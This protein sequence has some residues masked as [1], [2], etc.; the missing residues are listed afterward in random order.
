MPRTIAICVVVIVLMAAGRASAQDTSNIEVMLG[1]YG[2]I[3]LDGTTYRCTNADFASGA[4][5]ELT[6]PIGSTLT[7]TAA[8][9]PVTGPETTDPAPDP[10]VFPSSFVGW[11]RPECEGAGPSCTFTVEDDPE[12][13]VAHFSPVW[14]E[15]LVAGEGTVAANG[16]TSSCTTGRCIMGPFV[17]GTRVDVTATPDPVWGFGC[18]PFDSDLLA[19]H[20]VIE[21]S[22]IRNFVSVG[23]QDLEPDA[24]PPY[25]LSKP[26][27]VKR[28]GSGEGRV[29]GKGTDAGGVD[30]SIDCGSDCKL[31]GI[32]YQTRVRLRADEAAG[33]TF[34]RWSGPPCGGQTICTFTAGKYPTVRATFS[35]HASASAASLPSSSTLGSQVRSE[36]PFDASLVRVAARGRRA[37]RKIVVTLTTNRSARATLRLTRRGRRVTGRS[38]ALPA[39]THTIRVKVPRRAR[40]GWYRMSLAV[41]AADGTR[42]SFAKR[43]RLR[44]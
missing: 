40:A 36:P 3:T 33:S 9:A 10:A 19:G 6:A 11:S 34:E 44:R 41:T 29:T 8:P 14:L 26:V 15:V 7:F 25:N 18:D 23:F 37:K 30:W 4:C 1:G 20:C 5:P 32:Q 42:E 21:M 16:E 22:N 24:Q 35:R 31:K 12:A 13:I 39:G 27:T 28:A 17:A 43:L 38:F 2:D